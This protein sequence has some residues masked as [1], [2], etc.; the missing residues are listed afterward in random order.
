MET[1]TVPPVS[2]GQPD[3]SVAAVSVHGRP[4]G[5]IR[6]FQGTIWTY[7][8]GDASFVGTHTEVRRAIQRHHANRSA[9]PTE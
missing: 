4:A 2:F 8:H 7:E 1:T 9:T 6:R 3:G 5:Q